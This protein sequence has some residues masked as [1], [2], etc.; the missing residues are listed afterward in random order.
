M[1]LKNHALSKGNKNYKTY[2]NVLKI[3][4]SKRFKLIIDSYT[5]TTIYS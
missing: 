3:L 2:K 4:W 1:D 5:Y